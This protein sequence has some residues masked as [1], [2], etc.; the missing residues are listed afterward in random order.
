M[1]DAF[2]S[3]LKACNRKKAAKSVTQKSV[4]GKLVRRKD[5]FTKNT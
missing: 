1:D 4:E 3:S 2:T 5:D